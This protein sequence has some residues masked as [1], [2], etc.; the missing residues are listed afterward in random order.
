MLQQP[1]LNKLGTFGTL[2]TRYEW[3]LVGG[4]IEEDFLRIGQILHK[5]THYFIKIAKEHPHIIWSKSVQLFERSKKKTK[6]VHN[7]DNNLDHRVIANRTHS[8]SATENL[9]G[10]IK[11]Y[12]IHRTET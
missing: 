2:K 11:W 10:N 5:I 12:N 3:F 9:N 7:N 4:L 8:L 1:N 6:K